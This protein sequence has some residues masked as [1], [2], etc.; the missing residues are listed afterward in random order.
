MP[1]VQTQRV[2]SLAALLALLVAAPCSHAGGPLL[3]SGAG[4]PLTWAADPIPYNPDRGMLGNLSNAS[5][6]SRIADAAAAWTAVTTSSIS[7]SQ[8]AALPVD[9]TVSNYAAYLQVCG[10]DLSP[11]VFDSDGRITDDLF[12]VGANQHIIGF[13]GPACGTFDPPVITEGFSVFNGR[14][15]DG[16]DASNNPEL[17]PDEFDAV[18]LHEL[19]HYVG[20]DHSQVNFAEAA[21]GDASNDDALATMF[22]ILVNATQMK[23]LH[24]DDIVAVSSLYPQSSFTTDFGTITGQVYEGD[25]ATPFQGANVIA[26]KV[27]DPRITAVSQVSGARYFPQNYGGPPDP[28]LR[29]LF[30]LK[31]L[32]PG[33]YTVELEPIYVNFTGGSSVGPLEIPAG[34]PGAA[35]FWN[36]SDESASNP[37]DDP[38]VAETIDVVANSVTE[39]IDFVLNQGPPPSNDECAG[40]IE[41][42]TTP[43]TDAAD[44]TGATTGAFDPIQSCTDLFRSQNMNS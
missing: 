34:L 6:T 36:G 44:V 22:P 35:E 26:R 17:T 37:P 18:L 16:V 33:S 27:G 39:G 14:F 13:A 32:P 31:G 21:D 28:S 38:T 11:I 12:G 23:S 1:H 30:E 4:Q 8:A 20:L 19:G 43:F 15:L 29:A 5:A 9:V 3:V 42:P 25:G 7:L 24:L 10:D 2:L 40:A 41:I